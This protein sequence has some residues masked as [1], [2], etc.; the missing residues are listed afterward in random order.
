MPRV[1]SAR[2]T[3]SHS[4]KTTAASR[5]HAMEKAFLGEGSAP[6]C[7]EQATSVLLF[8]GF[9]HVLYP[10]IPMIA[11]QA[12][13]PCVAAPQSARRSSLSAT[14]ALQTPPAYLPRLQNACM[15]HPCGGSVLLGA[16]GAA[17]LCKY[18]NLA[19]GVGKRWL[20][21]M[22]TE[23]DDGGTWLSLLTLE[24]G[25]SWCVCFTYSI[26]RAGKSQRLT[27]DW[28]HDWVDYGGACNRP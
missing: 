10:T 4:V 19:V 14:V 25:T 5:F 3:S 16:H 22:S 24:M 23:Q 18:C 20:I 1:C 26:P 6:L 27:L 28:I 21:R 15:H 13:H 12:L 7:Q 17:L 8:D 9:D 11:K 2:I